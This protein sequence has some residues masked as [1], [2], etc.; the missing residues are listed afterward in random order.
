MPLI[1][2]PL[3]ELRDELP[4]VHVVLA[5]GR[6]DRRGRRRLPPGAWN[7]IC[8]DFFRHDTLSISSSCLAR[9]TNAARSAWVLTFSICQ[10]SSST[11]VAGRRWSR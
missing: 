5:Q 9:P 6:T 8:A 11:G 10:Y 3:V 2:G 4:D 1:S 7:L